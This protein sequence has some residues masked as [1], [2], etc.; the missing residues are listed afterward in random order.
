MSQ[1]SFPNLFKPIALG[2][3]QLPH[4]VVI[5]GHS[6]LLEDPHGIV[7]ERYQ[8]YLAERAAGGAALVTMG[9]APVHAN[10]KQA[11]PHT[12]LW[13]DTV[14][15]GLAKAADA[16]H[17]EGSK[18][19]VIL[20]HGGHNLSHLQGIVPRAPSAIPSPDSGDIPK[21][22]T[23]ADIDEL[24]QA[25]AEAARRCSDAGLDAVEVQTSS[26]YLLGSFLSPRL[27][28][29]SDA[30]GGPLENRVRIVV[31]VLEAVRGAVKDGVAVGVRTSAEH[32]IPNDPDGYSLDHSIAAMRALTELGL[33][34]WVSVMT[35]SHWGFEEMISPMNF[36]RAQLADHAAKFK[37]AL[38][39]PVIVAGRIRTPEEAEAVIANEQA[40][41]VAMA[42]SFIAD[43]HWMAKVA[44]GEAD[45]IRPCMSCN[46][47]CLG[48]AILGRGGSCV[49]NPR[50]GREHELPAVQQAKFTK[51]IAVVGGGP[52]GLEAARVA[53]QRGHRVTLYEAETVL[54]GALALLA[55]A[56]EREEMQGPI[57]W[58][59]AEL[60][61]LGVEVRLGTRVESAARLSADTIVWATGATAGISGVWRNRPQ[62]VEGIPGTANLPH[63]RDILAGRASAKG[64]VLVID[65]ESGWPAVAAVEALNAA[66]EV[67]S[68]TVT[69][70]RLLLGLPMLQYSVE[71]GLVTR[72]LRAAGVNVIPTTLIAKVEGGVATTTQGEELGPFDTIVLSTGPEALPVPEGVEA[73]GDCITPRTIWAAVTDGMELGRR[74]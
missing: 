2:P 56:P 41:V 67:E 21:A 18:L 23:Q 57:E 17:A 32:L 60:A 15:E 37:A 62:L 44:R 35:G 73:I 24:I 51:N 74:L 66:A 47:G 42:R 71:I 45:T 36:P 34:D 28:R 69:T 38:D 25:Y 26:N 10:S 65:E 68:V 43:P 31:Q 22:M 40:D 5:P 27:N 7:G 29:R 58:W 1:Q 13:T 72:R 61:R 8:G 3:M 54:G 52:A 63:S 9:S 53:A 30:Y 64:K 6:M 46:Q 19:S 39:V 12:W 50:A 48:F 70:D 11:W 49:I 59:T 33:T 4:R 16:V 55:G 20:W 14:C